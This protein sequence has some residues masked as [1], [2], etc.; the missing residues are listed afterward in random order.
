MSTE[1]R[2][3]A[4]RGPISCCAAAIDAARVLAN[5]TNEAQSMYMVL[6]DSRVWLVLPASASPDASWIRAGGAYAPGEERSAIATNPTLTPELAAEMG[7]L[8]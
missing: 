4:L 7:I 6:D 2:V 8:R 5:M 1:D 3:T